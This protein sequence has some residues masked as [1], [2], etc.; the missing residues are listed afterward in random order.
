MLNNRLF[1]ILQKQIYSEKSA[2]AIERL[3]TIT[4]KVNPDATKF[5]IKAAVEQILNLEVVS[6]RTA[7]MAGKKRRS[8]R[9]IGRRS[10]WKKA[11]VTVN[12]NTSL[13]LDVQPEVKESN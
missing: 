8:A 3:K 2:F 12:S 5:E 13:G 11:Y 7:N 1:D 10:D 4:F 6:V 9:G